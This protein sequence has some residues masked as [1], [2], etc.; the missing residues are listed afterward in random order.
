MK[1]T[2]KSK[3][4]P[5]IEGLI[6]EKHASGYDFISSEYFLRSFDQFIVERNL[7]CGLLDEKTVREWEILKESENLNTR[8]SRVSAVRL[9][10]EYMTSLGIDVCYPLSHCSEEHHVPYIPERDEL[11]IFFRFLDQHRTPQPTFSRFD[12]EYPILFRLYYCCGLRLNEAVV[13]KRDD[14][15]LMN[16]HLYIRHS[17]GDKDRLVYLADDFVLLFRAYDAKMNDEFIRNREWFFPGWFM[18]RHFSKHAIDKRF[19]QFWMAAFPK[20]KGKWPTIHSLRHAFVVHRMN[21]WVEDGNE[22]FEIMPYLSRY[23]GPSSIEETMYYY[24]QLDAHTNAVRNFFNKC[25]SVIREVSV[26]E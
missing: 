21:D 13:L 5:Y 11:H 3:L 23:L 1:K 20:W 15:D 22:L 4:A 12:I 14:V 24:H 26:C 18:D 17:K 19:H 7:D 16:G 6:A 9:L 8:N 25:S 10:A 2:F